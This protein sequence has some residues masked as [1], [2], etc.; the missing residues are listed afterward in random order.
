M[1]RERQRQEIS[2][3][4]NATAEPHARA[5]R[6]CLSMV[7][8]NAG[9]LP[10]GFAEAMIRAIRQLAQAGG[11]MSTENVAFMGEIIAKVIAEAEES[12]QGAARPEAGKKAR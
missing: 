2:Q 8:V 10:P 7:A 5:Y 11:Q 1:D 9:R 6:A 3:R 4:I 12:P